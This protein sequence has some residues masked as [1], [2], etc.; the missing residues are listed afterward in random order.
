MFAIVTSGDNFVILS[1]SF[2]LNGLEF[3]FSIQ[4]FQ[5]NNGHIQIV[6]NGQII[7][8]SDTRFHIPSA[9]C[10]L[11]EKALLDIQIAIDEVVDIVTT[12]LLDMDIH[13][14]INRI[15]VIIDASSTMSTSFGNNG[16]ELIG[17]QRRGFICGIVLL[18]TGHIVDYFENNIISRN[19]AR[20]M[21]GLIANFAYS[22]PYNRDIRDD[23]FDDIDKAQKIAAGGLVRYLHDKKSRY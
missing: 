12:N 18:L 20:E 7:N 10:I 13:S 19:D 5:N 21:L 16:K 23:I 15:K 11:V 22:S 2:G 4:L 17:K 6:E 9:E 3:N 1:S 8:I 14:L